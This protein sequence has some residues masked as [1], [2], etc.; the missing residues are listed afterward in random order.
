MLE[1][2]DQRLYREEFNTFEEFCRET[3]GRSKTQVNRMIQAGDVIKGLMAAG[4]IVM[5][6]CFRIAYELAHYPKRDRAMILKRATQIAERN[7][8][9]P[10]YKTIRE[11]A[12]D[13]VP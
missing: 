5:P 2:R 12:L 4:E 11:A 10:D 8:E 9:K 1:I 3:L 6:D 7:D 13:I